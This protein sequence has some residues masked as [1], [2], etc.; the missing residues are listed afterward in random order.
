MSAQRTPTDGVAVPV[1][2]L[3]YADLDGLHRIL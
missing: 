2:L 3:H 1:T